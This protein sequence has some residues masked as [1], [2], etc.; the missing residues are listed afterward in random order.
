MPAS[1]AKQLVYSYDI[2]HY[3]SFDD[4]TTWIKVTELN[5]F[6]AT[7]DASEYTTGYIDKA[8]QTTY[9]M[10]TSDSF[11]FEVDAVGP[12]GIQAELAQYEDTPNVPCLYCRT[13]AWDFEQ[14]QAAPATARV[15]KKADAI[16][17]LNPISQS[18][19]NPA[20]FSG[21][22]QITGAYEAGTFNETSSTF[23]EDEA[24]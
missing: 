3:L 23:T 24:A 21:T 10:G 8:T 20:R 1:T 13:C 6:D 9:R 7:R 16:M 15:A 18:S 19:G 11:A 4:G 5:S 12:D 22:V 14:G 2:Q 17:N